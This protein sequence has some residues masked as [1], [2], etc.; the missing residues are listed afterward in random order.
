MRGTGGNRFIAADAAIDAM[1]AA[2]RGGLTDL[3]AWAEATD[4]T[5]DLAEVTINTT[6]THSG[7]ISV[8]VEA[9][10]RNERDPAA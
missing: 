1:V 10:L 7:L 6:R 4:R 9:D 5:L 3:H 2:V 8:T